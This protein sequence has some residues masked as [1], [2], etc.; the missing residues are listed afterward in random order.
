MYVNRDKIFRLNIIL[1]Y[2]LRSYLTLVH[3]CYSRDGSLPIVTVRFEVN[4]VS[5][6]MCSSYGGCELTITGHGLAIDNP[7]EYDISVDSAPCDVV[8]SSVVTDD[9]LTCMIGDTSA[10]YLVT[11]DGYDESK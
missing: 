9:L 3:L 7:M 10:S 1:M 8:D 6:A 5:P 2:S 4:S 11:N